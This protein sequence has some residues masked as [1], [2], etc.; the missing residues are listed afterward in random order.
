MGTL[1]KETWYQNIDGVEGAIFKDPQ[2]KDSRYWGK[3]KWTAFIEP[4]LPAEKRT[5][6]EIGCNAGLFL[7]LAM[8]EGYKRVIGI[9]SCPSRMKQATQFRQSH[10]YPYQLIHQEVGVDFD[11]DQLPLADV[12]LLANVHYHLP[13]GVFSDL[14]DR[15]RNHT[16]YCLLV[17]AK[18]ARHKGKARHYL[19]SV[20]GYF[21]D[22]Q[23]IAVIGDWQ[24]LLGL[25][26]EDPA[27]RRQMYGVLFK[28]CL[29]S[30]NTLEMWN[31]SARPS[32][33][34]GPDS[35]IIAQGW[36]EFFGQVLTDKD[37]NPTETSLYQ[38]WKQHD[39]SE[40]I[41]IRLAEKKALAKDIQHNGMRQPIY[42]DH[43]D[44]VL[45]GMHR[46][47]LACELGYEHVLIRRL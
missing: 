43:R 26:Q 47:S 8:D 12:T 44:R 16:L 2:R 30:V 27:P 36:R 40:W 23:E 15:L 32:R 9:E 17:S 24:N 29:D 14:V 21:R 7:K 38:Y 33:A 19:E 20:R 42:L 46:L 11:L 25:D 22:W 31:E 1:L 41:Q 34:T 39:K 10:N 3:G 45:D 37:P 6:V 5:F 4:L 18:V 28:G 35:L 13:V